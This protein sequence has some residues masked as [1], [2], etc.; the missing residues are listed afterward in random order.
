[1]SFNSKSIIHI[2]LFMS[3]SILCLG[4]IPSI[5]AILY[6]DDETITISGDETTYY[7]QGFIGPL[8]SETFLNNSFCIASRGYVTTDGKKDNSYCI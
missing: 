7:V 8:Q 4:I 6:N 1:M 5:A 3:I 2:L